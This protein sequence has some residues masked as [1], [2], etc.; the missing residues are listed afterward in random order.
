MYRSPP[1]DAGHNTPISATQRQPGNSEGREETNHLSALPPRTKSEIL[2]QPHVLT[3][4]LPLLRTKSVM[5][6]HETHSS[7]FC[8]SAPYHHV[9][10]WCINEQRPSLLFLCL[11]D[12]QLQLGHSIT[13]LLCDQALQIKAS[14]NNM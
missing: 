12:W 10:S 9:G 8:H 7:Y 5:I 13:Y 2:Q 3:T 1:M 6:K 11:T 14:A 4:T